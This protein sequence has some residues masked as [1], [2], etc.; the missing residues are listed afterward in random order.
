MVLGPPKG[1]PPLRV[2]RALIVRYVRRRL[3]GW[4]LFRCLAPGFA[5]RAVVL[6]N[7]PTSVGR[8]RVVGGRCKRAGGACSGRWNR[9]RGQAGKVRMKRKG[10]RESPRTLLACRKTY[11]ALEL[12][13]KWAKMRGAD[14]QCF[15]I[16][17]DVVDT[18]FRHTILVLAA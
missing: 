3:A 8:F 16:S 12:G 17:H 7:Q 4:L 9:K 1:A 14:S 2:I 10:G 6:G 11:G 15:F 13:S 18:N 5:G